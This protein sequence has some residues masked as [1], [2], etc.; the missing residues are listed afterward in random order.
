MI[1]TVL[2]RIRKMPIGFSL[3]NKNPRSLWVPSTGNTGLGISRSNESQTGAIF[4]PFYGIRNSKATA[5]TGTLL[6]LAAY[7]K[8]CF[9]GAGIRRKTVLLTSV[10]TTN[11]PTEPHPIPYLPFSTP[12]SS[13]KESCQ[14]RS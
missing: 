13:L 1:S 11:S 6:Y 9:S 3:L 10:T 8:H 5:S 14:M 12:S 7:G 4:S 2:I